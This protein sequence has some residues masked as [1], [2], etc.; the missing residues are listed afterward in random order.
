MQQSNVC[1]AGRDP[2]AADTLKKRWVG[3]S[4][5]FGSKRVCACRAVFCTASKGAPVCQSGKGKVTCDR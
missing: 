2:L 3:A 4:S 5:W 1:C